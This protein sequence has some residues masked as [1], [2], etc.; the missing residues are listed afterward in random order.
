MSATIAMNDHK[1]KFKTGETVAEENF[2]NLVEEIKKVKT[3]TL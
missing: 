1:E 2:F 3:K